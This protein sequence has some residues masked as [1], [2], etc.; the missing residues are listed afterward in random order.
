MFI[1]RPESLRLDP[2]SCLLSQIQRLLGTASEASWPGVS[3]LPDFGKI[4]F[5]EYPSRDLA[6]VFPDASSRALSVLAD[7]L[8]L[9]PARRRTAVEVR[10]SGGFKRARNRGVSQQFLEKD[11]S[12]S[13]GK[14]RKLARCALIKQLCVPAGSGPPLPKF[15]TSAQSRAL[16][17]R[18]CSF[19]RGL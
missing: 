10:Y 6:E 4:L 9:D 8:V 11:V 5:R 3:S 16:A 15:P 1:Q 7:I 17:W 2:P 13:R 19:L 12:L 18:G 14:T